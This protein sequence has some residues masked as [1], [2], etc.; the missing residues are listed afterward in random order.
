VLFT[1]RQPGYIGATGAGPAAE[2]MVGMAKRAVEHLRRM[3][4]GAQSHLMRCEDGN[5]Y[6]VKFQNNP[7]GACILSN[8]L[9]AGRLAL[10]LGLPVM[11]PE[12]I[13]VSDWLVEHSPEMYLQVGNDR[14]RCASGLQFGSRFPC[15][16]LRT[17]VYDFLPDALLGNVQNLDGF[18]GMLVFDKWTCNC[19]SRQLVFH[20]AETD[21]SRYAATMIDQGYC[22]NAAEWN[23]PD[24]PLRGLYGRLAVYSQIAGLESFQPYLER[25]QHL[26]ADILEEAA[27]RV[28][29]EWYGARTE[30]MGELLN[31]LM[32][33]RDR[34]PEL[35][36]A[37]QRTAKN[38]FP[39]WKN[40]AK[41]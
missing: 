4:G 1:N 18:A 11:E 17:P 28:P 35:I 26:D 15:D 27:S 9:L 33:R 36:L 8:E 32:E 10:A 30:A 34:V 12:L 25:L 16:P 37:C 7:Q 38:P 19:D 13:E 40:G 20:R 21:S 5:Y 3:R 41:S 22:F 14:F 23:F 24:A 6:V 2:E 31:A 29:P 39:N